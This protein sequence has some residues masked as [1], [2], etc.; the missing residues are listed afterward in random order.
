[1]AR[2]EKV[3]T[4]RN[5]RLDEFTERSLTNQLVYSDDRRKYSSTGEL[6]DMPDG[7]LIRGKVL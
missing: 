2:R 3:S 4:D 1:M 6:C 5:F 7:S